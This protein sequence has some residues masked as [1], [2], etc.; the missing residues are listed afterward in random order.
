MTND[1]TNIFTKIIESKN[2]I[3]SL[4]LFI[5]ILIAFYLYKRFS[6][7]RDKAK[8]KKEYPSIYNQNHIEITVNK[9]ISDKDKDSRSN[10]K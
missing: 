6:L 4:L 10:F 1:F 5:F 3:L 7:D 2:P 9:Y 8:S